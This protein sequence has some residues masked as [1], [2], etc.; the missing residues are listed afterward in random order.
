MLNIGVMLESELVPAWVSRVLALIAKSDSLKLS[1]VIYV[2]AKTFG[3]AS[4]RRALLFGLWESFD[5]WAYRKRLRLPDANESAPINL[6][7]NTPMVAQSKEQW[8]ASD[9]CAELDVLLDFTDSQLSGDTKHYPKFGWWSIGTIPARAIFEKMNHTAPFQETG[10]DVHQANETFRV[11][12]SLFASLPMSL[13]L[14]RNQVSWRTADDV[15]RCLE[16][17]NRLGWSFFPNL[18]TDAVRT[19]APLPSNARMALFLARYSVS[20]TIRVIQEACCREDWFIAYGPVTKLFMDG[21]SLNFKVVRAPRNRFYAD[22]MVVQKDERTFVFFEDYVHEK[23]M[24]VIS[25]IELLKDGSCSAPEVVLDTGYHLSYPGVF[26]W[27]GEMYMIPET[28]ANHTI[29][30][31]RATDFPRGWKLEE[32]LF[33]DVSCVDPTLLEYNG[34]FWLFAAG[35]PEPNPTYKKTDDELHLYFADTP[36][37]PW[38]PHPKNPVVCDVRGCRPAGAFFRE[39]GTLI[40]PSQDCSQRYGRSITLNRVDVLTETEYK[41]VPIATIG[42]NWFPGNLGTHTY[43]RCESYQVVDGRTLTMARSALR[44]HERPIQRVD[45]KKAEFVAVDRTAEFTSAERKTEFPAMDKPAE[46]SPVN[47]LTHTTH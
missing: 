24:G 12:C 6:Q 34:K 9:E 5:H 37:G 33:K 31:Y 28:I 26:E 30:L 15:I 29:E 1:R 14:N 13:F 11:R 16:G 3:N 38:T 41:E 20:T 10:F 7:P 45:T 44:P 42:P 17:L 2:G 22:S 47:S 8:A 43:G 19:S 40:R 32:V 39:N 36:F 21:P 25:Y 27:H 4:S 18:R 35:T 23:G 46:F